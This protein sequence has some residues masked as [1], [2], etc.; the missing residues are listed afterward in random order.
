M[1]RMTH[2]VSHSPGQKS[3]SGKRFCPAP[4]SPVDAKLVYGA[5]CPSKHQSKL[6][7]REKQVSYGKNTACYTCYTETVPREERGIK[8]ICRG[9]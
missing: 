8:G 9:A 3:A 7:S 1:K 5:L 4:S 6:A 2:P